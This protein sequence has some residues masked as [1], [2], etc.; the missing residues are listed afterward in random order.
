MSN[1]QQCR[2]EIETAAR[3]E[4]VTAQAAEHLAVCAACR[5]FQAERQRLRQ[6]VGEL[7]PT[8]A[9]PDFEFRLRARMLAHER[10][11][12]ARY[13]WPASAPRAFGLVCAACL[14]LALIATLRLHTQQ[15]LPAGDPVA[16]PSAAVAQHTPVQIEPSNSATTNFA[17]TT[18]N[19]PIS[20]PTI[21]TP[22]RMQRHILPF[23]HFGLGHATPRAAEND[24]NVA[25]ESLGVGEAPIV[26]RPL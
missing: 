11:P 15:S 17:N 1:C 5:A 14:I 7:E 3:I 4:T 20:A 2:T 25:S 9:P 23:E 18:N 13:A 6:L 24:L 19:D 16:L 10:A 8:P 21:K 22:T 26:T 12:V